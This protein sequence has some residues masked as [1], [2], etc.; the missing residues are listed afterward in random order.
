MLALGNST[1]S[2]LGNVMVGGKILNKTGSTLLAPV[3]KAARVVS[4]AKKKS[5]CSN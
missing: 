4:K 3:S 1:I 5:T 2:A